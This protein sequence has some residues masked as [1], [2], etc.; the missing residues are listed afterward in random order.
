MRA[1]RGRL[2][3]VVALLVAIGLGL[4]ALAGLGSRPAAIPAEGPWIVTLQY[5]DGD[6][7]GCLDDPALTEGIMTADLPVSH[8]SAQTV[9]EATPVDLRRVLDCLSGAMTGG[10]V[11]VS[12]VTG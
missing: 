2:G 5:P 11:S 1:V 6:W 12:T 8:V 9:P 4:S 10:S 7:S 3:A